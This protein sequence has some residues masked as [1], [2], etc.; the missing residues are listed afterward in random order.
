MMLKMSIILHFP[1]FSSPTQHRM[2]PVL[3]HGIGFTLCKPCFSIRLTPV[4][5]TGGG[6]EVGG[7]V[8]TYQLASALVGISPC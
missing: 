6:V 4:R 8:A 1:L 5:W 3:I 2:P 7:I